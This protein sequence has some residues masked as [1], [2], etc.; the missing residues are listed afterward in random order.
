MEQEIKKKFNDIKHELHD[1]IKV[2]KEEFSTDEISLS[3]I[4]DKLYIIRKRIEKRINIDSF[5]NII[6]LD[7]NL[8]PSH[9]IKS[10][11]NAIAKIYNITYDYGL[12]K[13]SKKSYYFFFKEDGSLR[14]VKTVENSRVFLNY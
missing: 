5:I 10:D 14:E 12:V 13:G 9:S 4:D 3:E 6:E 1:L 8:K 2:K 7:D 11:D